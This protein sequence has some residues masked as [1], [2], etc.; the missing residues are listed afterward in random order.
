M[1][2]TRSQSKKEEL[3]VAAAAEDAAD[4]ATLSISRRKRKRPAETETSPKTEEEEAPRP[5][6]RP[7]PI[8]K[9]LVPEENQLQYGLEMLLNGVGKIISNTVREEMSAYTTPVP[10]E[11]DMES[12][13][14]MPDE[15]SLQINDCLEERIQDFFSTEED[16]EEMFYNTVS[17][18]AAK[19]M[20]STLDS[21]QEYRQERNPSIEGI[22]NANMSM[23][24]RS[25]LME[26]FMMYSFSTEPFSE[27]RFLLK[28]MINESLQTHSLKHAENLDEIEEQE[29]K[30]HKLVNDKRSLR[31]RIHELNTS[32]KNKALIY[33]MF[34]DLKNTNR[35][36]ED[37][38]EKK[39][40]LEMIL[41]FPF[42]KIKP[43]PVEAGKNTPEEIRDFLVKT[44]KNLDNN[45]LY[46]DDI[47]DQIIT[48]VANCIADPN[49]VPNAIAIEGEPGVGKS[50]LVMKGVAEA[51]DLPF[52]H[53]NGGGISDIHELRGSDK[54]YRSSGP[55]VMFQHAV[56]AGCINF[57]FYFD[58]GD[59]TSNRTNEVMNYM[60]HFFDKS[61][62]SKMQ[63]G[64]FKGIDFD[65]SHVLK[66][67]SYNSREELGSI[68]GDRIQKYVVKRYTKEQKRDILKC[69]IIPRYLKQKDLQGKI[70]FTEKAIDKMMA[71]QRIKES[72][73]RQAERN[74]ENIINKINTI[75][76]I[77]GETVTGILKNIDNEKYSE[78][79]N[80]VTLPLKVTEE[81][82]DLLWYEPE[83]E[84][85]S[86][87]M[88]I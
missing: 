67:V 79:F 39:H 68:F 56:E 21:L 83:E 72:G 43:L 42:N 37:Y 71:N 6:R 1:P 64:Y 41:N 61:T 19:K 30:Y 4:T 52:F 54:V 55:G 14:E 62:N 75:C 84:Q 40:R 76:M 73:M 46:M 33:E 65:F 60:I 2:I 9:D 5:K 27:E 26:L 85:F 86:G 59:K 25:R 47:K 77:S 34:L 3:S 24:D 7:R 69:I 15:K 49:Q 66:F 18:A 31:Q 23:E 10:E 57:V 87:S 28:N 70:I 78:V 50:T 53:I 44:R 63:D 38:E 74:A 17:K 11:L 45:I 32:E 35:A 82:I 29:K 36:N 51:L 22:L 58:E 88:Y 81:M 20:I 13:G 80:S 48:Y 12:P 8:I 16:E